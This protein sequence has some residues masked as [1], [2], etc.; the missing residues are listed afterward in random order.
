MSSKYLN[1]IVVPMFWEYWTCWSS[2]NL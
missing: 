1:R 2:T